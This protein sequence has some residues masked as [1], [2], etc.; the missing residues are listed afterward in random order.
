MT[1]MKCTDAQGVSSLTGQA[2]FGAF[3]AGA[4]W[5]SYAP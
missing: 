1:P 4:L 5:D 2:R 3:F